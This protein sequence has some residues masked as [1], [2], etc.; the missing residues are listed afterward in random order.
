[1]KSEGILSKARKIGWGFW[2]TFYING[3][4]RILHFSSYW[5]Y[6]VDP[7][8]ENPSKKHI[9][10]VSIWSIFWVLWIFSKN[11][12]WRPLG[13]AKGAK[14]W[15]FSGFW[16]FD[17]AGGP[18]ADFYKNEKSWGFWCP[19]FLILWDF[20]KTWPQCLKTDEKGCKIGFL[21]RF[22][23]LSAQ[24]ATGTKFAYLHKLPTLN[25]WLV[26]FY[27]NFCSLNSRVVYKLQL[28]QN[29]QLFSVWG[30]LTVL[31]GPR[32]DFCIFSQTSDFWFPIWS[33]SWIFFTDQAQRLLRGCKGWKIGFS[34]GFG[35]FWHVSAIWRLKQPL[36][37]NW[38]IFTNY[39]LIMTD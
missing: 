12:P 39:H 18:L 27:E 8:T 28:R 2:F 3:G 19:I 17:G 24:T 4:P 23:H 37:Q 10:H 6:L 29:L 35:P 25:A 1:M 22:S 9:L 26:S 21:A 11:L 38:L 7:F 32:A 14:F 20:F 33:I 16:A 36:G 30:P 13:S 5:P 34:A 31:K 15:R